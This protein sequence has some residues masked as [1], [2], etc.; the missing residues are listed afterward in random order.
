[1]TTD[2]QNL[3]RRFEERWLAMAGVDCAEAADRADRAR[4]R[5][6]R[7]PWFIRLARG[8]V[9]WVIVW[10][11]PLLFLRRFRRATTLDEPA[12]A[13]LMGA[14]REH[15]WTPVRLAA[16]AVVAPLMEATSDDEFEPEP[17]EHPL[18]ERLEQN[19]P[20]ADERY[21]VLVIG[22][23]A[24]G[25][26]VAARMAQQGARVGII[27][28]GGLVKASDAPGALERHYVNQGLLAVANGTPIVV[29]A[30]STLGGTTSINSG[31]S[32]K[33]KPS[34]RRGW[35]EALGT[36][37]AGE[38]FDRWLDRSAEAINVMTPPAELRNTSAGMVEEGLEA[39]GRQGAYGLP[40]C[41]D[42]CQ[43]S[44]RCC[45]GCPTGAKQSTDRAFLPD[46]LD[47]GADLWAG[48]EA[49]DI[50]E[51]A[52][53][54]TVTIESDGETKRLE[55]DQLVLSA[56]AI[57]TPGL[58]RDNCLGSSW[59]AAGDHF[60]THP[61]TKVFAHFPDIDRPDNYPGIPQGLGYSPP[62]FDRVTMEGAAMPKAAVGPMI[63][64]GGSRFRRWYDNHDH[65]VSYGAMI[66]DRAHGRISEVFGQ[67]VISYDLDRRDAEDLV[68]A[69]K[70]IGEVFFAAGAERVLLPFPGR[71][72]EFETLDALDQLDPASIDP[73]QLM[74]SGFHPQGTAGIGRL[75]DRN[76]R[77][78]GSERISVCDASVLPDSPGVNPQ[79]TIIAFA[80]RLDER[81]GAS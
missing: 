29:V 39:L 26:P 43:G 3:P 19:D 49:G 32:L 27:E 80:L 30:G 33:A 50:A 9:R 78:P 38:G 55:C 72:N 53:G 2:F 66:R 69:M 13:E 48:W 42:G 64:A 7:Y 59:R 4:A 58:I 51:G 60:K 57:Y 1:M 56:G 15:R 35:D 11:G 34:C 67:P 36:N 24:G 37:F 20:R 41:I 40:R 28:K 63:A 47:A 22:S 68:G 65:V 76:L 54:V 75:V 23:G 77:L 45:F 10:L 81:L 17:G 25:A 46:A 6:T 70:L 8:L 61:A 16:L 73:D 74:L 18:E 44:G 79:V 52:E 71:P 62:E 21:D 5:G 12:F 14:I 31:T